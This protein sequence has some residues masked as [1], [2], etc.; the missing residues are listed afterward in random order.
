MTRDSKHNENPGA[1][2]GWDELIEFLQKCSTSRSELGVPD[3]LNDSMIERMLEELR[4][5]RAKEGALARTTYPG[6]AVE[7]KEEDTLHL[8]LDARVFLADGEY[9][10]KPTK[11]LQINLSCNGGW[12]TTVRVPVFAKRFTDAEHVKLWLNSIANYLSNYLPQRLLRA[13][14]LAIDEAVCSAS[15]AHK[16]VPIDQA[17][18]VESHK[19]IVAQDVKSALRM[20]GRGLPRGT[21]IKRPASV[22]EAVN[23]RNLKEIRSAMAGLYREALEQEGEFL[24]EDAI[25]KT[26]VAR[27]LNISRTTLRAWLRESRSDFEELKAE[28][29]QLVRGSRSTE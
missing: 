10:G 28:V 22:V 15:H 24:A 2:E 3:A 14:E 27:R 16:V 25:K 23:R 8:E 26:S 7:V 11:E 17:D 9:E 21:R 20:R 29:L 4:S 12:L 18:L 13:A 5:G 1:P 6:M 19:R